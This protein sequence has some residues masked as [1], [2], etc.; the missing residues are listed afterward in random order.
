MVLYVC[1]FCRDE[2]EDEDV[3]DDGVDR[4]KKAFKNRNREFFLDI[5]SKV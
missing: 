1:R 5:Y 3:F 2:D 4:I